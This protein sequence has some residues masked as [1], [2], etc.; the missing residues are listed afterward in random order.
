VILKNLVTWLASKAR[1]EPVSTL[2]VHATAGGNLSGAL[3]TLK[4]K[5][6]SYHVLI[7][8][9][10]TIWK[11]VPL[12]RVAYHAGKSTGPMGANVNNY[13]IGICFVNRNDGLDPIT[14][15]Q[16]ESAIEYGKELVKAFPS[17]IWATTHFGISWGRKSDPKLFDVQ[18]YAKAIGLKAWKM[19]AATW[20]MF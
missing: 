1:K 10:G 9:D 6:F 13:S 19:P 12:S 16:L 3:S 14:D 11:A 7:D 8:K 15:K 17:L 2:V 4:A 18:E 5:G 20:R